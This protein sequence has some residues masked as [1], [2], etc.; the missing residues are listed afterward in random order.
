MPSDVV[1][2]AEDLVRAGRFASVEDV[3]RAGVEAVAEPAVLPSD[4][5]DFLRYRLEVGRAA[6]ARG[7]VMRTTPKAFIDAIKAELDL[8]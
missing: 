2:L 5:D 3:L 1:K 8:K 6:H 7:D 4:W